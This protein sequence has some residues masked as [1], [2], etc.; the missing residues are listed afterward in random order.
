MIPNMDEK[1]VVGL[2]LG[3][4]NVGWAVVRRSPDG[5]EILEAGT[6]V[7]DSPLYDVNKPGD[8]LKSKKRG[9]YRR[10]RR[11][12]RRRRQRKKGLYALLRDAG[13]LPRSMNE[14]VE[15]FCR[16]KDAKTGQAI[17]PYALRAAALVRQ[18]TP[19]ELGRVLCHLNQ[20][21]GFL[22]PRDLML[23]GI[24]RTDDSNEEEDKNEPGL[25]GEIQRTAEEMK[26]FPTIGAYLN[27]RLEQNLPVRKKKLKAQGKG[28]VKPSA[29]K[30][31]DERRFVRADRH[32]IEA[33]FWKIMEAQSKDPSWHPGLTANFQE[34]LYEHIFQQ[35]PLSADKST[36]GKCTFFKYELR[37]PRAGLTAQKFTI[38]KEVSDLSVSEH[39]GA[40]W[41][42]LLPEERVA[43]V[44]ELMNEPDLTW[45]EVKNVLGIPL[46]ARFNIE[47]EGKKKSQAGKKEKLRGSQTVERI[48]KVIGEKWD[49][50]GDQAQRD[51]VGEIVSIRD[52]YQDAKSNKRKKPAAL[53]RRELFQ[54]KQYGP[55][56][57]TFTE[58]EANELATLPLPEGYLSLSLKAIK[59]IMPHMLKDKGES[60]A[61]EAL[62][63]N[64]A[65]PAGAQ[66][67]LDRLP[68]PA[69]KEIG[70]A[71]VRTTVRSAVR[72]LNA[73]HRK[74]G[75]PDRIHIELP[76]DLAA[77]TKQ[78]EE[79]EQKIHENEKVRA[80]ITKELVKLGYKPNGLNI[81]KV[82]LW[83]ELGGAGLAYEPDIVIPDLI[84]LMTGD[85]EIDHIVPRS[86]SLD[87]AMANLTLC[88]REFNTQVK[89]N[90]TIWEA[91]GQ[92]D[93]ARW[94]TIQ[95]HVRSL[96]TMP[97]HKR[98]R[99]LAKERPE[100]FTGRHL[101]A[102]GYIS[103]E[104]LALAQRMVVNKHD[105]IVAPGR[106]TAEVRNFWGLDDIVPLHPEEQAIVDAWREFM[107][108]A[109]A[110]KATEEDVKNAKAP[111][112]TRSNFKHHALDAICVALADR[113]SL[114]ALTTYYQLVESHSEALRDKAHRKLE[115]A[116]TLPDPNLRDKV[117]AAIE[118]ASMVHRPRRKPTGELHKMG[119]DENVVQN[120]P[121]GEPWGTEV[122][123]K[124][125]VRYD[126]NGKAA[127][128]YPLGNN[129]HVVI[130]ERLTPNAKGE[131]ERC[132]D[133][134]PTIEA[135]RRRNLGEPVIRKTD[136][137][138][139][140]RYVM[141][142]VKGDMVEMVDGTIG[143]V[144]KFS[145]T[146]KECVVDMSIWHPFV[147]RQPKNK[148]GTDPYLV[149]RIQSAKAL[150]RIK[151]RIVMN[152]LG[153]IVYREG[154]HD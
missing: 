153:E 119:P 83:R 37:I 135:F 145:S 66:G 78:R 43:L 81:R 131:F 91:L 55:D 19:Y 107:E 14:R 18:L 130:Y 58:K 113:K 127:Q 56:K 67:A 2:D 32:M 23:W 13:F 89:G 59:K 29:Q 57:I 106:A 71:V 15:L 61:W 112:K 86:H 8:G 146:A 9:E 123:G 72:V 75:K 82:Q 31:E 149:E 17:H 141:A 110:G 64:H 3:I 138:P 46:T 65:E 44:H 68:Y 60:E 99:I 84:S 95:A 30:A 22:S 133:V 116:Q 118:A 87:S 93:P 52:W 34:Q 140:W 139:G 76:R 102:T 122:V 137:K 33:E 70:H 47:P 121:N 148:A 114:Q 77:S 40:E 150:T 105:V 5:V 125:L 36:R 6:F 20:K 26:D 1:L 7:F 73:L 104:V 144:S 108:R 50:L 88:T 28:E 101:A 38:A 134:V 111:G 100:G 79:T 136:A 96:K 27:H 45:T 10:A 124:H 24:A 41:R 120:L 16:N 97:L 39:P 143:V 92:T 62:G 126:Q 80:G 94:A 25:K 103:R 98:N 142:L 42:K 54:S 85:Y 53:R 21:R 51:L 115:K 90:K 109:E 147:A 11:T 4:N 49:A 151:S 132:A 48:K 117:R 74:Y 35:R 129:H 154:D 12:G 152:P 128:A 69:D 63:L